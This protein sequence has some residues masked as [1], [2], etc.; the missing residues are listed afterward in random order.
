[1]E[2]IGGDFYFFGGSFSLSRLAAPVS[3]KLT[4]AAAAAANSAKDIQLI[5]TS[6]NKKTLI[7][8]KMF[9]PTTASFRVSRSLLDNKNV[10]IDRLSSERIVTD[11]SVWTSRQKEDFLFPIISFSFLKKKKYPTLC[12]KPCNLMGSWISSSFMLTEI[13]G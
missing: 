8:I 6:S 3:I 10:G 4:A 12:K 5:L 11:S 9:S 1:M 7:Q 13:I 2:R